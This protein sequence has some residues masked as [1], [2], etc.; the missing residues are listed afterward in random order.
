MT[1]GW[2]THTYTYV[3]NN[4]TF[5]MNADGHRIRASAGQ[6]RVRVCVSTC[7]MRVVLVTSYVSLWIIITS[8]T[9]HIK[10]KIVFSSCANI[11]FFLSTFLSASHAAPALSL[12][13]SAERSE[14]EWPRRCHSN[15][16][17]DH[18]KSVSERCVNA[19]SIDDRVVG[20]FYAFEQNEGKN[21][22]SR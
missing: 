15:L 5:R 14:V 8:M 13:R 16:L 17:F 7:M 22:W 1:L 21:V 12:S 9:W 3:C 4:N 10:K 19:F 6:H 18:C 2:S 20:K 11:F